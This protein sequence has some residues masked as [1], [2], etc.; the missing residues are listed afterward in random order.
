MQS[1]HRRIMREQLDK[2]FEKLNSLRGVQPP[3]KGWLRSI[4][5]ALGM[6]GK[7]L[8]ERIGVSQPRVVQMEK[9]ELSGALTL[10][11]LR[12]VAEAMDCM[13]VYALV[14]R[15][16]LEETMRHQA[17]KVA[18]QRLSRT[19]HSMLLE[20]QQVSN[21]ELKKM[22]NAKVKDLVREMPKDLWSDKS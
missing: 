8:G 10:K 20:D 19:S 18:E 7:Q 11:T 17:I 4:R 21:D 12:Q 3:V 2:T 15:T 16:S 5:E 6:S 14:P 13:L 1:K 22:L 9:D